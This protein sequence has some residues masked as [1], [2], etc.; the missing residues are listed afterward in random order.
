MKN[1]L[2]KTMILV[3]GIGLNIA[4][5]YIAHH[6]VLPV[7]LDMIGTCIASYYGGLWIGILAGL[8]NNLIFAIYDPTVL[9]YA[10]TSVTAAILIHVFMKKG[11]INNIS[12]AFI[13]SFWLGVLCTVVSTPLNVL[14][15]GG[16][17][18]NV[19]GDTLVDM[20]RWHDVPLVISSLAGEVILEIIDKQICVILAY[21]L[22]R[23][24]DTCRRKKK[25]KTQAA[26]G[27]LLIGMMLSQLMAPLQIKAAEE[28]PE[29]SFTKKIYNN[30]NGMVSSEANSICGT[31][32]G[33]IWLGSYAGLTRYDGKEFEFIR[34]G[35]LVNV[36]CM[37][38]DSSGRLWIGTNDAGIARYENGR[39]TYF[40]MEDGLPSNT[41]KCFAEDENGN[42]YVGT[43]DKICMFHKDDRIEVMGQGI[44]FA[45]VMTVYQDKLLV[46]D[47]NGTMY[48]IGENN[49]IALSGYLGK[50]LFFYSLC[51]TSKGLLVGT[52][53]GELFWAD[54]TEREIILRSQVVLAANQI[55][56]LY[57]D[58]AGRIWVATE[59][60]FGY[61]DDKNAYR[62]IS[63]DNFNSSI[64][65]FFED[66]QGNIWV[67]S[68]HYGVMKLSES[69]F[70]NLFDK[71]GMEGTYTNAVEYYQ[72]DFYCGTDTGLVVLNEKYEKISNELVEAVGESRV[73]SIMADSQNQLWVCTYSGL[74]CQDAQGTIHFY[75]QENSQTTSDRFRCITE[76]RDGS[77][78]V[79][80]ADGVNL[81]RD[82]KLT[83]TLTSEEGL[84]NTQI[85]SIVEGKDGTI[86]AGSDGSGIYLIS[87]GKLIG[88][89]TDQDGLSS[90]VILRIVPYEKGYLI[91][92]SNALCHMDLEGNIKKLDKFPYFNNYDVIIDGDI[93]YVTCSA[94]LYKVNL[95]ELCI[96][97]G[98][99]F[100]LY[101]A[102]DGLVSGLTPNS[103]NYKTEDGQLYLCSN[104][105]IILFDGGKEHSREQMKYGIVS[106][107][108]D[109][110]ELE[111]ADG[112]D[113]VV[114]YN[115]KNVSIYASVRNYAFTDVKV[116]FFI[117]G[118]DNN[119]IV[120]DWNKVE[121]IRILKPDLSEYTICLQILD[122]TGNHVLQETNYI[123]Q[124][125]LRAWERP[126]FKVYL[127]IVSLEILIST[128]FSVASMILFILR[129]NELELNQA[130]LEKKV[131]EQTS[132]LRSQQ[133]A[134][135]KLFL[136]T[137][138][139]LSEAVDAKDRY[140]SGHSKRVAEYARMI[141][142]R[143]G[144][145]KEEQEEIYR[146]GLLH[147]VG[148]IRIPNSI[149][150]KEGKLTDEEFNIIKVHPI[151]G[152]HILKGIGGSHRIAIAT[153]YHHERYDGSGYPNRISGENIP[154]MARILAV[155]DS[156]DAMTSNRSYR[157]AL[158]REV[159]RSII[160][161][162]KG[163]QFDPAIADVM[164]QM[165]D[166]DKEYKM[167]QV[168]DAQKI[169]L[170]VDDE[171]MNHKVIAHIMKDEPMYATIPA[172]GGRQALDILEKE[173]VDL[174][175][176]DISMPDLDGLETLKLIREE[177]QTPVVLMTDENNLNTLE[178]FARLD[179]DEYVTKP[180]LP[181]L[182]KEV[183]HNM[184]ERT[185]LD[186][187]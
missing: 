164:L 156:Y 61:L 183:I 117:K 135:K 134:T 58:S 106:V 149:I 99:Q 71:I 93:A 72:G 100:R 17:S 67:A 34:E 141:A 136:Q 119:P 89:Y 57:E 143:M 83:G 107:Q 51:N 68:S 137:V 96:D 98:S 109:G 22:I 13:A 185:E 53:T 19:W 31:E 56:A 39:Y 167:R 181:L 101:G 121:P 115:A 102:G 131:Q 146:A 18:G 26:A 73:R 153:K 111:I 161:E 168:D 86:W 9:I 186:V 85:L 32:D 128:L 20:L 52:E 49:T 78:A 162:G 163:T 37:M 95:E 87:D 25:G 145:D 120:C 76:L 23:I 42:V 16:Y 79:G 66:Y 15:N 103:W 14:G 171:P 144:K 148:K 3:I 91:V 112:T 54:V 41:V 133:K 152:Y 47:N 178:E 7:W 177:Y 40:T 12:Q 159:V 142:E 29:D 50:D 82:E 140:T 6:F 35:G 55:S 59:S 125:E 81:I 2:K 92:T 84:A 90:N 122:S 108:C 151:T 45:K 130:T 179:C 113:Y 124:R 75:N 11:F 169:I 27:I 80:T 8:S 174:I 70:A 88:N 176:L 104:S 48:A 114:P 38:N 154:E 4:G 139:A 44:T 132:E 172:S 157:K 77:V 69:P 94:G 127:W 5:R 158:P 36:V 65:C 63:S 184:T 187:W 74:F 30:T 105:G 170:V 28:M 129:K 97:G 43:S 33:Y 123:V 147:D 1:W 10:A 138:T 110:K 60:E 166:E 165:I 21:L 24:W 118:L 62:T 173:T 175:L 180:F 155:A 150:N 160:E 126:A 182:I 46:L 116:R 64:E